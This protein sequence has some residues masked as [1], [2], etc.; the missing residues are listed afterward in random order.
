[1]NAQSFMWYEL[2]TTDTEAAKDFYKKVIGWDMHGFGGDNSYNVLN[3]GDGEIGGIMALPENACAEGAHPTWLGYIGVDDVDGTAAR[4]TD[5]GGAIL[6]EPTDIP[7][8]GRMAVVADPQGAAFMLLKGA[9]EDAPPPTAFKPDA[10]RHIGWNELHSKD[11]E[12]AFD[13]YSG[14]FG[15]AKSDAMDMGDMGSYQLVTANDAAIGAMFNNSQAARP[16]WL[17]YINVDDIDAAHQRVLD[18]GGTVTLAPHPVPGD[19]WII[20]ATD[21]QGAK[22]ALVGPRKN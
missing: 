17:F 2:I 21:P 12:S 19:I 4:V 18:A 9:I 5:A 20:Q 22:F 1:M 7:G 15:W 10:P 13:F 3:A 11:W 16:N 6:R 8:A 14:L